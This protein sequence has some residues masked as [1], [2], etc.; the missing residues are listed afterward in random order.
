MIRHGSLCT[1]VTPMV[2]W[3]MTQHMPIPEWRRAQGTPARK[4]NA[5]SNLPLYELTLIRPATLLP[6]QQPLS[7][8]TIPKPIYP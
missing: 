1:T 7:A 3:P 8:R 2:S 5:T 6:D 4:T